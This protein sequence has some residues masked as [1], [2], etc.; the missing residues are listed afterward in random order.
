MVFLH[1]HL[2]SLIELLYVSKK[3]LPWAI[4]KLTSQNRS[5]QVS[6]DVVNKLIG[7]LSSSLLVLYTVSAIEHLIADLIWSDYPE[8]RWRECGSGEHSVFSRRKANEKLGWA[9]EKLI[10]SVRHFDFKL[11]LQLLYLNFKCKTIYL[12]QG[13][14]LFSH[15][16]SL[17]PWKWHA[18][19]PI[20]WGEAEISLIIRIW[21]W[22]DVL[23]NYDWWA[24]KYLV[25]LLM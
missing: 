5:Q 19:N 10:K 9:Y 11:F 6:R 3:H 15:H 12:Y 14:S 25:F 13:T 23:E 4:S 2:S 7:M 21:I 20:K 17:W 22:E 18:Q 24:I 8:H 1:L 16:E